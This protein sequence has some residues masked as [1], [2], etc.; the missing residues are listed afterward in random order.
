VIR[1]LVSG[2]LA[3]KPWNGGIA[4]ARLSLLLGLRRLGFEVFFVEQVDKSTRAQRSYFRDVLEPFSL[5]GALIDGGHPI[6]EDA[7]DAADEAEL[8]INIGGH[9]TVEALK[10]RPRRKVFLDD[11]PG[12]TQIWHAAGQIGDRLSGHDAYFTY[13]TNI[14]RSECPIPLGGVEWRPARPGIVLSEWPRAEGTFDRFTT[15]ASW[16]GAY[17]P[18][19]YEGRRYGAK[20]HEF[21]KVAE[22]PKLVDPRFEIAL[23]IHE[24]DASDR[25]LLEQSGWKLVDPRAVAGTPTAFRAYVQGSGAEFSAAQGVYVHTRSGWFSDRS[26]CYLAAGKPVLLQDTG[27]S[28]HLPVGQGLVSFSTVQ[29]A[30]RRVAEIT[31]A[32]DDHCAAAREVAE[33]FFDSDKVLGKL[34]EDVL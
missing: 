19:E 34:L 26:A 21:R 6:P 33:D 8:L 20:A 11:D 27:F 24:A 18:L 23:E 13:G 22:L 30:A 14:G 25:A 15:V 12:Y 16:R 31:S 9:L 1:A 3:N 10:G 7:L 5:G 29:D 4:W 32:Y 2:A 17:G 28:S